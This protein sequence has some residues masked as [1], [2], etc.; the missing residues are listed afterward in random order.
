MRQ[1]GL[2]ESS[3]FG[4]NRKSE[5]RHQSA[6]VA[7]LTKEPSAW[8]DCVFIVR[9]FNLNETTRHNGYASSKTR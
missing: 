8:W 4:F 1:S 9:G 3:V 6:S 5:V 7:I 2:V